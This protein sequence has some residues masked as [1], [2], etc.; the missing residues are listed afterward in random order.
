[1][2]RS[3]IIP[4]RRK[5]QVPLEIKGEIKEHVHRKQTAYLNKFPKEEEEDNLKEGGKI[6][7]FPPGI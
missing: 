5:E 6:L 7:S 2:L 3:T 4:P 1:M